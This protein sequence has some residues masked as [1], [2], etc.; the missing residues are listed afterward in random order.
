MEN[1]LSGPPSKE[2]EAQR[3]EATKPLLWGLVGALAV[4]GFIA[5]LIGLGHPSVPSA[6]HSLPATILDPAGRRD[7]H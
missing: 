1:E 7:V 5:T 2:A 4:L 3:L 6:V